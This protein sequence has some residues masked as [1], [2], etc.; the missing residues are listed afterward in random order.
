MFKEREMYMGNEIDTQW[1]P[2]FC[3]AMKLEL[4]GNKRDL[5]FETEHNINAKPIM[6]DLLVI[7][8]SP[9]VRIHNEIGKI[10]RGTIS[11]NTNPPATRWAL[12]CS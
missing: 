3:S 7:R 4:A 2:T 5:E 10:L 9:D 6:I 12:R 8:K 11:L 1:H